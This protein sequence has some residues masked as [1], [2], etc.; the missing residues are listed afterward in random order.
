MSPIGQNIVIPKT[1]RFIEK[2]PDHNWQ[3]RGQHDSSYY[4]PQPAIHSPRQQYRHD[5]IIHQDYPKNDCDREKVGAHGTIHSL[6]PTPG[7]HATPIIPLES[8]YY[9]RRYPPTYS[10][11]T[12]LITVTI[13]MKKVG[14][15]PGL[16]SKE[17]ALYPSYIGVKSSLVST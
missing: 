6:M 10:S 16:Q 14:S 17:K 12:L 2:I 15:L 13:K 9:S 8:D 4:Q 1:N 3:Y 5:R 7:K 11:S